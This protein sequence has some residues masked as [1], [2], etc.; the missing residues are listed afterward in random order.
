LTDQR[1]QDPIIDEVRRNREQ[2][3]RA[4]GGSMDELFAALKEAER[5]ES[6]SV[7]KLPPRPVREH[8]SD[9]A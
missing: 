6:R 5:K 9:A 1:P 2:L 4:S 8:G 7:V 3:L